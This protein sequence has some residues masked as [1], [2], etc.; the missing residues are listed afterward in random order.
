MI[1]IYTYRTLTEADVDISFG[2]IGCY[3]AMDCGNSLCR[4]GCVDCTSNT[5]CTSC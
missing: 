4:E 2:R 1:I 5:I 3:N